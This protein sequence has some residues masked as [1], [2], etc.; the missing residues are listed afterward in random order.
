MQIKGMDQ[1]SLEELSDEL[2]RGGKF[3]IYT[4]TISIL[5]MTFRRPSEIYFIPAGKSRFTKGLPFTLGSMVVGWWGLPWGPIYTLSSIFGN[6]RGK[7][8]TTEVCHDIKQNVTRQAIQERTRA[9]AK[10][11]T[12]QAE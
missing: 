4:W 7:D 12:A 6:V 5:V 3:V 11:A 9:A 1:L 10:A 8:V 2:D